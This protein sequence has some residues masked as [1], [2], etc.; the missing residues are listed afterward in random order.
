MYVSN[1]SAVHAFAMKGGVGI[2]SIRT[3]AKRW[4][5]PTPAKA[6]GGLAVVDGALF[7]ACAGRNNNPALYCLES[8]ESSRSLS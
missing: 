7:V 5:H 6:L 1:G 3:G 2:G 8:A 4:S